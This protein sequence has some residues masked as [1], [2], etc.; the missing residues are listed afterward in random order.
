VAAVP[1]TTAVAVALMVRAS[2]RPTVC[3]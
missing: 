3:G 2:P 1:L